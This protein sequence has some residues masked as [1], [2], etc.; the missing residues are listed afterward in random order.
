METLE[1][2]ASTEQPEERGRIVAEAIYSSVRDLLPEM[3]LKPLYDDSNY[4]LFQR[5]IGYE[6]VRSYK[7][8]ED[9][10]ALFSLPEVSLLLIDGRISL[11]CYSDNPGIKDA[12]NRVKSV[13]PHELIASEEQ[14]RTAKEYKPGEDSMAWLHS[15]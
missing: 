1:E 4:G 14:T 3:E 5:A 15:I 2:L 12:V 11:D 8:T 13:I 9:P 7:D 10:K 6:I